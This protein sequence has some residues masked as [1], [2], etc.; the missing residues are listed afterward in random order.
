MNEL[1][2]ILNPAVFGDL[3][4]TRSRV[5]LAVGLVVLQGDAGGSL[6]LEAMASVGRVA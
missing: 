1:H 6:Q 4:G 2:S 3:G 5:R